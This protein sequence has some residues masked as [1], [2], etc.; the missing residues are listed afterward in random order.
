MERLHRKVREQAKGKTR[1][2]PICLRLRETKTE[3]G[4]HDLSRSAVPT[5]QIRLS[6]EGLVKG[7]WIASAVALLLGGQSGSAMQNAQGS[8]Y[9]S[10]GPRPPC[11][12]VGVQ[13]LSPEYAEIMIAAATEAC[14]LIQSPEFKAELSKEILRERCDDDALIS[15]DQL[16]ASLLSGL[17]DYWVLARKPWSAEAATHLGLRRM[18]IRKRRF[19]DWAAG[20]VR[21]SYMID[22]L[23][24]EMT[25]L[26]PGEDGEEQRFQDAGH[27]SDNCPDDKLVSYKTGEIAATVWRKTRL[28][29]GQ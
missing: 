21:R 17:T 19:E 3:G 7:I 22:T 28:S 2:F 5:A 15:G 10:S 16:H 24:H 1:N 27:G 11:P 13:R 12:M 14:A 20:G 26:V 4:A 29:Q 6:R 18:M 8:G 25:H 23:V 9:R